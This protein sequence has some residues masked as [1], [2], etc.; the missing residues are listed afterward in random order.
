VGG[1]ASRGDILYLQDPLGK[2]IF[3]EDS[4]ARRLPHGLQGLI[5][6]DKPCDSRVHVRVR[7]RI[8][9]RVRVGRNNISGVF[10]AHFLPICSNPAF[11][12]SSGLISTRNLQFA[13]KLR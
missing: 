8:R 5:P 13:L 1:G 6:N 10:Y 2:I 9:V 3:C 7:I 11:F 12:S 4:P